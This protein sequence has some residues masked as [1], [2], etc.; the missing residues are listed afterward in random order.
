VVA[1]P[2]SAMALRFAAESDLLVVVPEKMCAAPIQT[3]GLTTAALPLATPALAVVAAWHGRHDSDPAHTWL[4]Q[5]VQR[6]VAGV[7]GAGHSKGT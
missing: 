3:L 6:A 4:R 5:Q 7:L 1:A 2:T